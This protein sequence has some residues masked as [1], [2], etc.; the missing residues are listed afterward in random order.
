MA[1]SVPLVNDGNI[2]DAAKD[3]QNTLN[4][5]TN[6]NREEKSSVL[7]RSLHFDPLRVVSA[8]GNYLR[9]SNGRRVF[10]AS[11]GA[12]VACLGHGNER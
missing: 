5:H 3:S 9:L 11:G 6:H 10:D 1:P 2:V 12:A 7:H 4:D 8:K